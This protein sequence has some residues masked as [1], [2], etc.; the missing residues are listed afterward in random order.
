MGE[1]N[2]EVEIVR[3]DSLMLP[4]LWLNPPKIFILLIR[5]YLRFTGSVQEILFMNPF[6][7]AMPD[8]RFLK[9]ISIK[10]SLL[11]LRKDLITTFFFS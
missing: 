6:L 8:R 4:K 9:S 3:R 11:N 1:V 5:D 10:N 2:R 7:S